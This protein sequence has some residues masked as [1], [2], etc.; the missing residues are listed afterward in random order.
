[1]DIDEAAEAHVVVGGA[2]DPAGGGGF[3]HQDEGMGGGIRRVEGVAVLEEFGEVVDAIGIGIHDAVEGVRREGGLPGIRDSVGVFVGVGR[4]AVVGQFIG[5][6]TGPGGGRRAGR[7]ERVDVAVGGPCVWIREVD[8]AL[9]VVGEAIAV[10][11]GVPRVGGFAEGVGVS[12]PFVAIGN[13]VGIEIEDG[14]R[15]A[16]CAGNDLVPIGGAVGV[17]TGIAAFEDGTGMCPNG[18]GRKPVVSSWA[19][20]NDSSPPMK[21]VSITAVFQHRRRPVVG[22][23][24]QAFGMSSVAE[25]SA[26]VTNASPTKR[27]RPGASDVS[28]GKTAAVVQPVERP[29]SSLVP[30]K[31]TERVL[32]E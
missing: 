27:E 23:F 5:I 26:L 31:S 9:G 8:Q 24:V 20:L 14:G 4:I 2:V 1:M 21:T 13:A 15:V 7:H 18:V 19:E 11:I 16:A 28:C 17:D 30:D 32:A 25:R 10:G 29:I 22:S 6:R 12:R 3:K